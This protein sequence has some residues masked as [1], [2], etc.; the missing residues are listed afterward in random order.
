[1]MSWATDWRGEETPGHQAVD[2]P[3]DD[4][5]LRRLVRVKVLKPFRVGGKALAIGEHVEIEFHLF[6]DLA[7]LGKCELVPE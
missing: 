6:R 2:P 5:K 7:A 4:P 1:M 3:V